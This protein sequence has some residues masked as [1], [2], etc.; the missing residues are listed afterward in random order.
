MLGA[1]CAFAG[2]E[3]LVMTP[4]QQ[5]AILLYCFSFLELITHVGICRKSSSRAQFL[6]FVCDHVY[7]MK[8]S[9]LG[10]G[11]VQLP[12]GMTGLKT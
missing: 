2:T 5:I 6:L 1:I 10:A 8:W 7:F 12:E 4:S 3:F 9:H 11:F